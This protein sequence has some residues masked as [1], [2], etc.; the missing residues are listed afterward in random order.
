MGNSASQNLKL[1]IFN[2][3]NQKYIFVRSIINY[4]DKFVYNNRKYFFHTPSIT[5]VEKHV[6]TY[7]ILYYTHVNILLPRKIYND[8][9]HDVIS[10][11]KR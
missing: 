9:D 4:I 11:M 10:E 3:T 1:R 8:S 6:V 5:Y 7:I 2:A